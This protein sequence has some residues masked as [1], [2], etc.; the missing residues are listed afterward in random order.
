MNISKYTIES[1]VNLFK[2]TNL[3]FKILNLNKPIIC[4]IIKN[5]KK[6][7]RNYIIRKLKLK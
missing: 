2:S 7:I 3:F 5:S 4:I 1:D 6:I